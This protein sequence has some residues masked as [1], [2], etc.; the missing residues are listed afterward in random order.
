M[1]RPSKVPRVGATLLTDVSSVP[2]KAHLFSLGR[3][4]GVG[5][6]N[7]RKIP[8]H[9]VWLKNAEEERGMGK[10]TTLV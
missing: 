6:N 9:A 3:G 8:S 7:S 1:E 10:T 5:N 4:I 2:E